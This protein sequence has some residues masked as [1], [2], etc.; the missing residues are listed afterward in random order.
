[1][2]KQNVKIFLLIV[3]FGT[4]GITAC[5]RELDPPEGG[6][7]AIVTT[8]YPLTYLAERI[9]GDRVSVTQLVKPGVEAHDFEPAPS[10]IRAI[11]NADVFIFNHPAFEG[12]ALAAASASGSGP[13]TIVQTV[14]LESQGEDHGGQAVDDSNFDAHVWL[15]PLE[16]NKQAR[17]IVSALVS[18]DPE[19]SVSYV[20]NGDGIEAELSAKKSNRGVSSS[21]TQISEAAHM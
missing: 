2:M 19:G 5:V 16:A 15:N 20:Q 18:A 12:W 14:N 13:Q 6:S 17:R 7:V 11:S 4:F 10:D 8:T 1:M 9:G 3:I 21:N